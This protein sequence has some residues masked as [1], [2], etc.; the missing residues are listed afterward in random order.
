ME[1]ELFTFI[2]GIIMDLIRIYM[3]V[4]EKFWRSGNERYRYEYR[5]GF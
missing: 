4:V 3:L 1:K 2:M 5:Y